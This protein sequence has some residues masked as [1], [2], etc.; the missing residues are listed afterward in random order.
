MFLVCGILG[1]LGVFAFGLQ[2]IAQINHRHQIERGLAMAAPGIAGQVVKMREDVKAGTSSDASGRIRPVAVYVGLVEYKEGQASILGQTTRTLKLKNP[3]RLEGV[4]STEDSIKEVTIAVK[5]SLA[6]LPK[7]GQWWIVSVYR[8][9]SQR[10]TFY[11]GV[12]WENPGEKSL[13]K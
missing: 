4:A 6:Q 5:E 12:E 10:N 13:K 7:T 1:L 8:D 9:L 2:K 11:Q 3:V